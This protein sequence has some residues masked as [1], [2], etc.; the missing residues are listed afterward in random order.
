MQS[1]YDTHLQPCMTNL[2]T[3][4][5]RCMTNIR[6][7][8]P[9]T[10]SVSNIEVIT[11]RRPKVLKLEHHPNGNLINIQMVLHL[12][13]YKGPASRGFDTMPTL[14]VFNPCSIAKPHALQQLEAEL[15]EYDVDVGL[16]SETHLK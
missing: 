10:N 3:H 12:T 16:I 4:L 9:F 1:N 8:S 7:V 5:Q 13:G 6:E 2:N 15:S 11:G 14:F